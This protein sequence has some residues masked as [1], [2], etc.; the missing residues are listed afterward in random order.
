[1]KYHNNGFVGEH[2]YFWVLSDDDNDIFIQGRPYTIRKKPN[3][4]QKWDD[5]E[6]FEWF[7]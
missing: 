2:K 3:N 1:M 7:R 4:F 5:I 6:F